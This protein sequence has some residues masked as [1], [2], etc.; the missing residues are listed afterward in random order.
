MYFLKTCRALIRK[1]LCL[2][3]KKSRNLNTTKTTVP[4][5][6][7]RLAARWVLKC[8]VPSTLKDLAMTRTLSILISQR[9]C[10]NLSKD[11]ANTTTK[12]TLHY[13]FKLREISKQ[14]TWTINFWC[15][16]WLHL[17]LHNTFNSSSMDQLKNGSR[18][19]VVLKNKTNNLNSS[20]YAARESSIRSK[21]RNIT[22]MLLRPTMK[23]S[24]LLLLLWFL[25]LPL[26]HSLLILFSIPLKS[27]QLIWSQ[28]YHLPKKDK[29]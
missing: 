24:L 27:M 21:W 20:K 4:K 2:F 9:I 8:L 1:W 6:I 25:N 22:Q 12:V 3:L 28:F 23:N 29:K 26:L 17:L 11:T 18:N 14:I 7:E 15:T 16:L 10:W 5:R 19:K 13:F